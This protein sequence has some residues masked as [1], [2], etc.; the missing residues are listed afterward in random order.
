MYISV[1]SR[2]IPSRL[3]KILYRIVT[4][5]SQTEEKNLDAFRYYLEKKKKEEENSEFVY[6]EKNKMKKN[7]LFFVWL[8]YLILYF[9]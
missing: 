6:F 9:N 4:N 7:C 3:L 1:N 2:E 5:C 8:F